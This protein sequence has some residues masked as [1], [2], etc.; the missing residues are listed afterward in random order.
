[1]TNK[2][3]VFFTFIERKKLTL[4]FCE[5][6]N[7]FSYVSRSQIR[8]SPLENA[9]EGFLSIIFCFLFRLITPSAASIILKIWDWSEQ[10]TGAT[11]ISLTALNLP[12]LFKCSFSKRKK[13]HMN[14]LLGRSK[15]YFEIEIDYY[16][17]LYIISNII[18]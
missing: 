17:L 7:F 15:Y 2:I 12:Q 16:H 11:D 3:I 14:L 6:I 13:F 8:D 18:K 1:M 5:S 9:R 10:S 4:N